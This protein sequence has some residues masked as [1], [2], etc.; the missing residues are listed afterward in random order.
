LI[1]P[2][3]GIA[4]KV[5]WNVVARN[6]IVPFIG[7]NQRKERTFLARFQRSAGAVVNAC[8]RVTEQ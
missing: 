3:N 2:G 8:G 1:E 5:E 4:L 6:G 7:W